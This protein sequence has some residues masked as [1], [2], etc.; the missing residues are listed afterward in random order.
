MS[1]LVLTRR[2]G[3]S[4]EIGDNSKVT[5]IGV[6]GNHVRLLFEVPRNIRVDRSEIADLIRKQRAEVNGN[7]VES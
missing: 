2:T 7:T 1:G 3:E 5:V 6:C 4:V